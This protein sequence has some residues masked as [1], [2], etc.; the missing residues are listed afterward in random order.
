MDKPNNVDPVACG[1]A[2]VKASRASSKIK[3]VTCAGCL[4]SLVG[5]GQ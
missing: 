4:K 2:W 3:E 1:R 5:R